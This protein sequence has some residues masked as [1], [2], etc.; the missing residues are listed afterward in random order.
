[1][2]R[3]HELPQNLRDQVLYRPGTLGQVNTALDALDPANLGVRLLAQPL[4]KCQMYV[5]QRGD[6][7][8]EIAKHRYGSANHWERIFKANM[9]KI[10]NPNRIYPGQ[11]LRI[12]VE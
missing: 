7:L 9:D 5:V 6:T 1:M 10:E 12:P 8:G 4:G 3:W 11:L 2:R